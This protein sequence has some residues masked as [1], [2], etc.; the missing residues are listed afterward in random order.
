MN[1]VISNSRIEFELI[2]IL[3]IESYFHIFDGSITNF[4]VLFSIS[5]H[6]FLTEN[7]L[8]TKSTH[9]AFFDVFQ[10]SFKAFSSDFS[11]SAAKN[12]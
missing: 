9:F 8:S 12:S 11:I 10:S 2:Y 6:C 5:V 7:L 4:L 3:S 1:K